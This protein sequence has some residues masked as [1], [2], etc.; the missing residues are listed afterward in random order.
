M[1]SASA[2][3][4]VII[5]NTA[6]STRVA[7]LT[8]HTGIVYSVI[9]LY[10]GYIATSAADSTV[11]IWKWYLSSPFTVATINYGSA[12]IYALTDLKNGKIA[13]GCSDNNVVVWSLSSGSLLATMSGAD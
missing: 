4:S 12:I 3:F 13:A 7:T 6:S 8:G 1:A 11:R 5:W 2:D 10:N 9:L